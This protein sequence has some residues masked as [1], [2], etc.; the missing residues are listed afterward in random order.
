MSTTT[1]PEARDVIDRALQL[2]EVE[3]EEIAL[4]LLESI[5][6]PPNMFDSKEALQAELK[7]R[8]EAVENGTTKTYTLEEAMAYWRQVDA[9]GEPQ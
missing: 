2:S 3:R 6:P 4:R 9:E 1:T 5:S 8:I 7:R